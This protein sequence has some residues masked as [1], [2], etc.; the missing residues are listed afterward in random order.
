MIVEPSHRAETISYPKETYQQLA[1]RIVSNVSKIPTV[2]SIVVCGSLIKDTLIPGWS[3]LDFVIF[4]ERSDDNIK[5]LDALRG[6]LN[7]AKGDVLI[8][9][10]VD[11]VYQD[12]FENGFRLGGRPLAMTFEVAGY[13]KTLFGPNPFSQLLINDQI[14]QLIEYDRKQ[15]IRAELHNWR[16]SLLVAKSADI[17]WLARC[18]KTVLKILKH[19]TD[20]NLLG[21]Y[22]YDAAFLLAIDRGLPAEKLELFSAAVKYRLQWLSISADEQTMSNSTSFLQRRL[23][24]YREHS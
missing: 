7:E 4:L 10:G 8:G 16:R 22:T 12:T 11:L 1:D 20:P 15:A 17:H 19:E 14:K 21:P 3:D 13:G 18:T 23:S 2:I 9:I 24:D 5:Q 6:A